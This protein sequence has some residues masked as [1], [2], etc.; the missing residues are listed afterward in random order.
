MLYTLGYTRLQSMAFD[1]HFPQDCAICSCQ[2]YPFQTRFYIKQE[3]YSLLRYWSLFAIYME[4][5]QTCLTQ[6]FITH[7]GIL[8]FLDLLILKPQKKICSEKCRK[9]VYFQ[10]DTFHTQQSQSEVVTASTHFTQLRRKVIHPVVSS[11]SSTNIKRV[12]R[13]SEQRIER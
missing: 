1:V 4:M 6:Y 11:H 3:V 10:W 8:N 5:R 2:S 13:T 7:C 12:S 9:G